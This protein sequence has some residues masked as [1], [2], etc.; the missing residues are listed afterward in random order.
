[1]DIGLTSPK[2]KLK[3]KKTKTKKPRGISLFTDPLFSL[4]SLLSA[5]DKKQNRGN[6]LTASVKNGKKN[7]PT[8]VYRLPWKGQ[9]SPIFLLSGVNE[10]KLKDDDDL[11]LHFFSGG[12]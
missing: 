3:K 10:N 2:Q 6:L 9:F 8:S 4:L 5:R 7:K 1:M 12:Y 11:Y